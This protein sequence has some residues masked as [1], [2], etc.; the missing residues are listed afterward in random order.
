MNCWKC[1]AETG[2]NEA[3]CEKCSALAVP[4]EIQVPQPDWSGWDVID[5]DKVNT[6]DEM[7]EVMSALCFMIKPGSPMHTRLK[8]WLKRK[9]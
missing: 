5:W 2:N 4:P 6:L 1:G 9:E 7:K 8:R 3:E